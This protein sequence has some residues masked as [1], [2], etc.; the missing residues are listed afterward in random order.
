[1]V[2]SEF[3]LQPVARDPGQHL[4]NGIINPVRKLFQGKLLS[5]GPADYPGLLSGAFQRHF[6]VAV[7]TEDAG[8]D[9]IEHDGVPFVRVEFDRFKSI[10]LC[11]SQVIHMAL[12]PG[13]L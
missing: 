12:P 11:A 9:L 7:R 13:R 4:F 3:C 2:Q 1:L 8:N 6:C 5:A 10:W